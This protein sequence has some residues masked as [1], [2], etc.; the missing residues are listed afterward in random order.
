MENGS[1]LFPTCETPDTLPH[2]VMQWAAVSAVTATAI[3]V[4]GGSRPARRV[5]R[6]LGDVAG[7]SLF[8]AL[9]GLRR[10]RPV[11]S[12]GWRGCGRSKPRPLA[13]CGFCSGGP[14][15]RREPTACCARK[16]SVYGCQH[17]L[18]KPRRS[19]Y[20]ERESI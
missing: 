15:I 18:L 7:A 13:S 4:L 9:C 17:G 1:P 6:G 2:P 11:P 8:L 14:V 16:A 3:G 10:M 12:C 5:V 20:C 19:G